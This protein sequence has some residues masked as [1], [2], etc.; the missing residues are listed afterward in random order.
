M[1]VSHGN[2]FCNGNKNATSLYETAF[3]IGVSIFSVNRKRI[4]LLTLFCLLKNR[5]NGNFTVPIHKIPVMALLIIRIINFRFRFKRGTEAHFRIAGRRSTFWRE[6]S[7]SPAPI[8]AEYGYDARRC[9][10]I[11][12]QNEFPTFTIREQTY[13]F[14]CVS[15][16]TVHI[17]AF[18]NIQ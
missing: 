18:R 13:T 9:L 4:V 15:I 2:I 5:N 11:L 8:P 17:A 3:L 14:P 16:C 7:D 6:I 1:F 12:R 10:P